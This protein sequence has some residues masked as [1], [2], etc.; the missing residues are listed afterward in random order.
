[1]TRQRENFNSLLT[2][3]S[4]IDQNHL[5]S[6]WIKILLLILHE[7]SAQFVGPDLSARQYGSANRARILTP[8]SQPIRKMKISPIQKSLSFRADIPKEATTSIKIHRI[9]CQNTCMNHA[10]IVS[11]RQIV[12]CKPAFTHHKFFS[13]CL[14]V[15][16]M[17]NFTVLS[18]LLNWDRFNGHK[19]SWTHNIYE[20]NKVQL[21]SNHPNFLAKAVKGRGKW[22]YTLILIVW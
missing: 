1:M 19:F 11:G 20:G 14:V 22:I 13:K 12:S 2:D 18:Q 15:V 3:M 5:N 10:P 21:F 16:C 7:L 4:R 9:G 6:T 17:V 8:D